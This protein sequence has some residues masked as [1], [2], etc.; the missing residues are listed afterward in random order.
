MKK[1]RLLLFEDCNRDC[2]GCCNKDWDLE[3]LP[4]ENDFSGYDEI[5][6]TGGE[7]MLDW[8]YVMKVAHKIKAESDAKIYVYTAKVD[9]LC[10]VII[11]LDY[12]D[13]I[14]VTI[15]DYIDIPPFLALNGYLRC[16]FR[17]GKSFRL[18]IFR[19]IDFKYDEGI[20]VVKDN[21]DWIKDCPLPD[22]ETLARCGIER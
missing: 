6:L 13:G 20:W 1:L 22:N 8:R 5:L 7:P 19:G 16:N 21:I 4:I 18:N 2:D 3:H 9:V 10:D 11:V 14:T 17:K 12:V 15:H